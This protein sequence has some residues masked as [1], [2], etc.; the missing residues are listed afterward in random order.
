M[1]K[2]KLYFLLLLIVFFVLMSLL[3]G[4]NKSTGGSLSI[5]VVDS[6]TIDVNYFFS[7]AKNVQLEDGRY[8]IKLGSGSKS[9]VHRYN[10]LLPNTSYTFTLRDYTT[11]PP[12]VD[13][14]I[15]TGKTTSK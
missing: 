2:N 11:D 6:N 1:K 9:G 3:A 15:I 10:D 13:L 4:C 7:N 8:I 12:G 14:A 5:K